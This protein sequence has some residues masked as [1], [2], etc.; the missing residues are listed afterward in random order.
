MKYIFDFII[1]ISWPIAV[2]I[3]AV[4]L[5][6]PLSDLFDKIQ[7]VKYGPFELRLAKSINKTVKEV[8]TLSL[9]KEIQRI[10]DKILVNRITNINKKTCLKYGKTAGILVALF[11]KLWI[12]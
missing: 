10:H 5:R 8:V 6:K 3:I 2:L 4:I 9:D 1:G 11:C 7:L 12:P